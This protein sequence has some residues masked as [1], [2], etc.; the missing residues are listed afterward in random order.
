M[1]VVPTPWLLVVDID[2]GP[3]NAAHVKILQGIQ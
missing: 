1:V 2:H 3:P